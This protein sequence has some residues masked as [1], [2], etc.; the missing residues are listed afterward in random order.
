MISVIITIT[1]GDWHLER[2]LD[3]IAGQNSPELLEI[4]VPYVAGRDPIQ[5]ARERYPAIRFVEVPPEAAGSGVSAGLDHCRY[6]ARR[7]AGLRAAQGDIIAMTEDHAIPAPDWLSTIAALH[8]TLP[9]AVIGGTID[10][11]ATAMLNW[12]V[13]L[14]DFGRYESPIMVGPASYVS[15]INVSY[16]RGPLEQI[17]DCWEQFYHETAVHG[18]LAA[19]GNVLWLSPRLKVGYDRGSL[20]L[21]RLVR[22]RVA[23]A[24]LFAAR[25]IIASGLLKRVAFLVLTPLL[26]VVL[27]SRRLRDA[28]RKKRAGGRF[29]AVSPL[30]LS[31]LFLSAFGEFLGYL[32][33]QAVAGQAANPRH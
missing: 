7:A 33:G 29:I 4:V 5:Q 3:A 6:D 1:D 26:P 9:H 32:T 10:H 18:R 23:W 14:V 30:L 13:Y 15:D 2:C 25:R 24:R 16:K 31:L 8:R 20:P 27:Y 22:E 21:A 12:A 28:I 11:S 19:S 17:R